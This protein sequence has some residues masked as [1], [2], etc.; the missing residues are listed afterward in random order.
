MMLFFTLNLGFYF[1]FGFAGRRFV[2]GSLIGGVKETQEM[3]DFCG[4]HNISCMIERISIDYVNTAL[5]RLVKGDV[6]Y[7]FV[8]DSAQSFKSEWQ[9]WWV[10]GYSLIFIKDRIVNTWMCCMSLWQSNLFWLLLKNTIIYALVSVCLFVWW[11]IKIED[12]LRNCKCSMCCSSFHFKTAI[13]VLYGR[14]HIVWDLSSRAFISFETI[15]WNVQSLKIGLIICS[16]Y[17]LFFYNHTC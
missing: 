10:K 3:L 6:K 1:N 16:C 7:H 9:I 11:I 2:G 5:E 4:E 12:L 13:I 14:S 17:I 8:I 15:H